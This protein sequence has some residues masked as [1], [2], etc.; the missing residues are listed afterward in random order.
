MV[1]GRDDWGISRQKGKGVP[2]ELI[3]FPGAYHAFDAPSS[4]RRSS[5]SGHHLEFNQA[6]TD[7][8]IDALHE[9]LIHD[10]RQRRRV[11]P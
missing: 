5:C 11:K 6:A 1:E 4:R 8:A 10:D 2:I 9:F 3:V 7:Q